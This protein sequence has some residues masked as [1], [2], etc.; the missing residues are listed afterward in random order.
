[1]KR[2]KMDIAILWLPIVGGILLGSIAVS[3]WFAG[4]KVSALWFGFAGVNC[5]MLL[6]VLQVQDAIR[7]S[8]GGDSPQRADIFIDRINTDIVVAPHDEETITGYQ[9]KVS[10]RDRFTL[11]NPE[12]YRT[13]YCVELILLR[14]PPTKI[15]KGQPPPRLFEFRVFEKYMSR[16]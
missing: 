5:F 4:N 13:Q 9:L 10:Y 2:N 3:T 7:K 1:M 6:G 15:T 12:P 16:T 14:P 8:E 11:R